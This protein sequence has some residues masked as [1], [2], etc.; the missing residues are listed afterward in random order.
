M[1]AV[2]FEIPLRNIILLPNHYFGKYASSEGFHLALSTMDVREC[3]S[4]SQL[5][6]SASFQV[7]YFKCIETVKTN[8]QKNNT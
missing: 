5:R 3:V 8:K 1:L 4:E 7:V 2:I 6:Y